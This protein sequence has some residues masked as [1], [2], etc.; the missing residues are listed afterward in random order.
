ML[1]NKLILLMVLALT[2]ALIGCKGFLTG[3]DLD[4]DPNRPTSVPTDNLFVGVQVNMYG[5]LTGPVPK[6]PWQFH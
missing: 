1:K 5:V 3:E 6:S 4:S 2:C